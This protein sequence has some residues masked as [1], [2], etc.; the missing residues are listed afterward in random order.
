MI[1]LTSRITG[2]SLAR[3][4]S[5]S[6]SSSSGV[7]AGLGFAVLRLRALFR[8]EPVERRLQF[9]RHRH[10]QTHAAVPVAAATASGG[11]WIERVGQRQHQHPFLDRQRQRA[12]RAQEARRDRGGGGGQASG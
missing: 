11:E 10:L 5:R 6:A 3:S 12:R 7:A 1:W 8:V 4:F 2:A 9:D